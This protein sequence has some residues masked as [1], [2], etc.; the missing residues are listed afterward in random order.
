MVYDTAGTQLR[1][2]YG[3]S[4]TLVKDLPLT[5]VWIEPL[6][7]SRSAGRPPNMKSHNPTRTETRAETEQSVEL[8][9]DIDTQQQLKE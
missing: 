6:T 2:I 8:H 1:S 4:S 7:N 3:C 5:N 9:V